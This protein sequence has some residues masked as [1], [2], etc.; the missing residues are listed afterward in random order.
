MTTVRAASAEAVPPTHTHCL[1]CKIL[2]Q[3]EETTYIEDKEIDLKFALA[4]F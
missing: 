2:A 1:Y 3:M 4:A